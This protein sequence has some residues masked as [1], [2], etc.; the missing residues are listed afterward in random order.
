MSNNLNV[1]NKDYDLILLGSGNMAAE[2]LKVLGKLNK[3]VAI[4]GRSKKNILSLKK[5]YPKHDFFYGGLRKFILLNKELPKFAINCVDIE[6][7]V[8]TSKELI[9]LGFKNILLEKPGSLYSSELKSLDTLSKL[10]SVKIFIGY[11]RRFFSSIARLKEEVKKDG[12]IKSLN[13]E[14][15]EWI[16]T[17]GYETHPVETLNKWII[18]NSSHVIDTA[19]F[20]IGKPSKIKIGISG[21]D[22]IN[23]HPSGSIFSGFGESE[24][25]I[26]FNYHTNWKAPGRWSIEVSTNLRRFYLKPMEK[27]YVQKLG[28]VS[29]EEIKIRNKLDTN[30][31]PGLYLQTKSF[32]D[33]NDKSLKTLKEQ[34]KSIELY[35]KIGGYI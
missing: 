14:F 5:K 22:E 21:A 29:V 24:L 10:N 7:L 31:K 26:P 34:V 2:Y 18:A 30:F 19:F 15:T 12:G 13:F 9:E 8:K 23:W 3:K 4:V 28:S 6:N 1:Q 16:H 32:L 35:N 11:N 17:F 25:N 27:L 20:L 33:S